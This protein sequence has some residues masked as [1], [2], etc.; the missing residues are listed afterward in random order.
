MPVTA[1]EYIF[2]VSF[3]QLLQIAQHYSGACAV[4]LTQSHDECVTYDL[5][6]MQGLPV[7]Y[8]ECVLDGR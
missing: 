1:M 7:E 2:E 6:S 8:G 5:C 4:R 3:I